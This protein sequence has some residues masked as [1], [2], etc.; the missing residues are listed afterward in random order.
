[1]MRFLLP[2]FVFL[3]LYNINISA[4]NHPKLLSINITNIASDSGQIL[5][6]LYHSETDFLKKPFQLKTATFI[7][8]KAQV[9][10]DDLQEGEYAFAVIHDKNANGK[11]DFN[12]LGIPSEDVASSNNVKGFFGPPKY[13]NAVFHL[14][15]NN[16]VQHIKM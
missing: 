14:S 16:T 8:Q 2:F 5:V 13:K 10:F 12:L 7:H 11:L 9:V 15:K 1:M 6:L 4:Q 3:L